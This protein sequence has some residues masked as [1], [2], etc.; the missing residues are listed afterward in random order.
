MWSSA[1][2][3][4]WSLSDT[5]TRSLPETPPRSTA[6]TASNSG[7]GPITPCEYHPRLD[8]GFP[9]LNEMGQ[10]TTS[11]S[12]LPNTAQAAFPSTDTVFAVNDLDQWATSYGH[13]F[14]FTTQAYPLLT[15]T[16]L[17]AN[18]LD[19]GETSYSSAPLPTTQASFPP[20]N[21]TTQ[22]DAASVTPAPQVP[23]GTGLGQWKTIEGPTT[24]A[25]D[26]IDMGPPETQE[27]SSPIILD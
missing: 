18:D 12:Y 23:S 20:A 22:A 25:S 15:D 7:Y 11:H 9:V 3:P 4:A 2:D 13:D 19:Q 26:A 8:A 24:Q 17:P 10:W 5:P 1:D 21:G 14:S 16:G 6:D 27:A